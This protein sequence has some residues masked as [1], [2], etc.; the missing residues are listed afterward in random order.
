MEKEQI[1]TKTGIPVNTSL[2]LKCLYTRTIFQ[3]KKGL[4]DGK[5]DGR[6]DGWTNR[7]KKQ[8]AVPLQANVIK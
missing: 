3:N 5:M 6:T 2:P 4:M 8:L 1:Q 7:V